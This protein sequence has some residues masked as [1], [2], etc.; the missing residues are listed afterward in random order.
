MSLFE[1]TTGGTFAAL[2]LL[3]E[4]IDNLAQNFHGALVDTASE[5]LERFCLFARLLQQ[6]KIWLQLLLLNNILYLSYI[7]EEEAVDDQRHSGSM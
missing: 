3:E 4:N 6:F 5:L 2:K 1:A 7:L